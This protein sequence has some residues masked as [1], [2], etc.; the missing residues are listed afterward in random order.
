MIA[1]LSDWG[2]DLSA[3]PTGDIAVA[4][5]QTEVQKRII[6][7]L[8]T[9]PGDYIWHLTYGAG[10]G[11]YVGA[12]LFPGFIESTILSQILLESLVASSPPPTVKI[13][14]SLVA[15][16]SAASVAVQYQIKGTSTGDSIVI[17]LG[18]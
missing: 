15:A 7:R 3:G 9:N 1:V 18:T 13:D 4:P 12:P 16:M 2:G 6:R 5:V 11:A 8:L 10:L 14:Q 17:G